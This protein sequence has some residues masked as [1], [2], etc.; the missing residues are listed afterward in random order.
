MAEST[1]SGGTTAGEATTKPGHGGQLPAVCH[2][3]R[4]QHPLRECGAVAG[5]SGRKT[6][7]S[8]IGPFGVI[9]T[10]SPVSRP[11]VWWRCSADSSRVRRRQRHGIADGCRS[12]R[13]R[14]PTQDLIRPVAG[15]ALD[16]RSP[17]WDPRRISPLLT[18]AAREMRQPMGRYVTTNLLQIRS[19]GGIPST[20]T[21][22]YQRGAVTI[23]DGRADAADPATRPSRTGGMARPWRDL[24]PPH[25][26]TL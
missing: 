8:A 19:A 5:S 16:S 20:G 11:A 7:A 13:G 14:E 10:A 4:G 9:S 18:P 17:P 22:C 25:P 1:I 2:F 12:R 23:S 26:I 15:P 3:E 24:A 21:I 6:F